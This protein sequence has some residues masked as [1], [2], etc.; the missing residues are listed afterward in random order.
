MRKRG[1]FQFPKESKLLGSL[2][3]G[4]LLGGLLGLLLN[5]LGGI[6]S[7][8][9]LLS[10]LLSLLGSLDGLLGNGGSVGARSEGSGESGDDEGG[11]DLL[12]DM[13]FFRE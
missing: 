7:C 4:V 1:R 11:D 8:G 3:S 9:I 2:G 6:L 13:T 12:H 5:L 10:G